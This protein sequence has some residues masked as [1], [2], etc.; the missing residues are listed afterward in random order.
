MDPGHGGIDD[1]ASGFG[2]LEDELNLQ[3]AKIVESK[4][5]QKGIEVKMSRTSDVYISLAERAQMA[6]S[7]GADA[8]I[9][10]HQNSSDNQSASGIETYYHIDKIGYK[11]YSNEIQTNAIQETG[12]KDRG[13]KIS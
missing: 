13:C 6:N 9:S 10:I 2:H 1:G 3:V 4:L 11:P 12:A 5:K 7:Y 8:F